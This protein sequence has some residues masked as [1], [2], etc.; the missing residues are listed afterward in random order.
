MSLKLL[1]VLAAILALSASLWAQE[2]DPFLGI[3][4]LNHGKSQF[5]LRGAPKSQTFVMVLEAG[6]FKSTRATLNEE[7]AWV[8]EQR[9]RHVANL[10]C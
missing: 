6:G 3:W 2:K 4:E 10:Q 5:T 7:C 9:A 8:R 1:P